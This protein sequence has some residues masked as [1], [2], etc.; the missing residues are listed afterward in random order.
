MPFR[1][2]HSSFHLG[3]SVATLLRILSS[4]PWMGLVRFGQTGETLWVNSVLMWQIDWR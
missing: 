3:E 4:D 2:D 1:P